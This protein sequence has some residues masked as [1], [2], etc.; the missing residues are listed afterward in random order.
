MKRS[1]FLLLPLLVSTPALANP[2]S[3]QAHGVW[4]RG[5]GNARVR[6]APCGD[7]ICATNVWIKD[8]SGGES[9]G[10]RLVLTLEPGAGGGFEGTAYDPQ[11]DL[12]YSMFMSV[13]PNS[14][15]TRGCVLAEL[16]CKT[17]SWSRVK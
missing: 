10:D 9:V 4:M 7:K 5:D 13:Q 2:S 3:S 6:I 8:T 11:R 15:Q 17:V 16:L 1:L 14:L 12:T